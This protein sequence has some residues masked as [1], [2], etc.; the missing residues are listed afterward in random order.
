MSNLST[1]QS[2][3]PMHYYNKFI[4][5]TI[6]DVHSGKQYKHSIWR[7]HSVQIN[8]TLR[9]HHVKAGEI[10]NIYNRTV[11]GRNKERFLSMRDKRG[12]M[13][14]K[15]ML[16]EYNERNRN[17]KSKSPCVRSGPITSRNRETTSPAGSI[18]T[19]ILQNTE[20][21]FTHCASVPRSQSC[22]R[23]EFTQYWLRKCLT[24]HDIENVI[25]Q[26]TITIT[27]TIPRNA[28]VQTVDQI[29]TS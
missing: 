16:R 18:A 27:A 5:P 28:T 29:I 6:S 9:I 26:F 11:N 1:Y 23:I 13:R 19:C 12:S 17:F 21:Q 4:R 15:R 25:T 7:N 2:I 20:A 22:K 14:I 10:R 24:E 8:S 3:Q